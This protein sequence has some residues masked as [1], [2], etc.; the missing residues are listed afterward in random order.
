M[1]ASRA[2]VGL[3]VLAACGGGSDPPTA[4]APATVNTTVAT[5][6][7]RE[8]ALPSLPYI[9]QMQEA[10]EEGEQASLSLDVDAL[11]PAAQHLADAA[12]GF[13]LSLESSGPV[14]ARAAVQ[15]PAVIEATRDVERVSR[16]IAGCISPSDC[17]PAVAALTVAFASWSSAVSDLTKVI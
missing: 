16:A 6:T 7:V 10:F 14:P 13:R 3:L 4:A 17:A 15:G 2:V 12:R 1:W 9:T 8:W 5:R 11:Q